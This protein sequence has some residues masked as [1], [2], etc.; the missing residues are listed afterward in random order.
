MDFLSP[1][2]YCAPSLFSL[3]FEGEN[4][5]SEPHPFAEVEKSDKR[6]EDGDY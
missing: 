2:F 1:A 4:K 3:G 5:L 6:P